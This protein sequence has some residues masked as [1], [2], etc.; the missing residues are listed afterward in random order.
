MVLELIFNSIYKVVAMFILLP[1]C[2]I[3]QN[4]LFTQIYDVPIKNNSDK[5]LFA[6]PIIAS[7]D[8]KTLYYTFK[9]PDDQNK[10]ITIYSYSLNGEGNKFHI[11]NTNETKSIFEHN[12]FSILINDNKLVLI[13]D[14]KV[15]TFLI[16]YKK[17]KLVK[18]QKNPKSYKNIYKLNDNEC[19][20]Y[21]NYN[22]H[23]L[24][25]LEKHVWAKY[26]L[27]NDS[28]S[29]HIQMS[30]ENIKF[31]A[32][33]NAWISVYKGLIAYSNTTEYLIRLYN[34]DFKLVDSIKSN[35][36]DSN[37]FFKKNLPIEHSKESL[38]KL[39]KID[40][41]LFTRIDKIFLCDSNHLLSV[42]K[43][44]NKF[45]PL[46]YRL[47]MWEKKNGIWEKKNQEYIEGFYSNGLKY[48]ENNQPL[49]GIIGSYCAI[50]II[51]KEFYFIEYPYIKECYTDSFDRN[52]DYEKTLN[53]MVKTKQFYFA[54]RKLKI[55]L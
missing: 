46:N 37:L 20:L 4:R 27:K 15:Y 51:D 6:I 53:D 49:R 14:E 5:R 3:S 31:S 43:L 39:I 2:L 35:E 30:E 48:D 13:N 22:F 38:Y 50:Q 24:D 25:Q 28:I 26:Y 36:L 34:S 9:I 42:I 23:P 29:E 52:V 10:T 17:L 7:N 8:K 41:S 47:D 33:S 54:I 55:N 12:I 16:E 18:V 11:D 1:L 45:K 44:R 32:R 19:L 21:Q 40:D